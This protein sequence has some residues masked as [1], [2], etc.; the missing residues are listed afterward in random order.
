MDE[1]QIARFNAAQRDAFDRSHH[2]FLVA[3]PDAVVERMERIVAAP[4]IRPGEVVLDVGTGT[5]ALIPQIRRY[6]PGGLFACDLSPRM[7]EQVA[8]RYS[9]VERHLCDVRELALPDG[10]VDVVFMNG[11][12][13]NIIDKEGALSNLVRMLA[14]GGRVVISHPEGRGFV[15][16]LDRA[17]PFPITALPSEAEARSFLGSFGL[18]STRYVDEEKLFIALALRAPNSD[19]S[20]IVPTR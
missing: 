16:Q 10:A 7:L 4:A 17:A 20:A 6:R 2:L 5:G 14:P 9:E 12:Y 18:T 1:E 13:G 19:A 11:M 3:L 15:A 8:R